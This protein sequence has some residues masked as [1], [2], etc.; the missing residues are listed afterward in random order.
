MSGW[1]DSF[2]KIPKIVKCQ[3]QPDCS[4]ELPNIFG[5]AHSRAPLQEAQFS[6]MTF[7]N[8]LLAVTV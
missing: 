4:S 1:L 6:W 7:E 2:N 8:L 5:W 3:F